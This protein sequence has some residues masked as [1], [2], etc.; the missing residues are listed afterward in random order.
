MISR[1]IRIRA[2][3]VLINKRFLSSSSRSTSRSFTKSTIAS[4]SSAAAAYELDDEPDLFASYS[5]AS[6]VEKAN[7]LY[8]NQIQITETSD[9]GYGVHAIKPFAPGELVLK[10][11]A[12]ATIP[13][14]THTLQK[15]WD[16]HIMVDVPARLLNHS[17][18]AN[19]G[20]M[21]NEEGGYDFIAL[22][23]IEVGEELVWDYES[24]EWEIRGFEKCICG[25]ANCRGSI[26]GFKKHGAEVEAQ[27]GEYIAN[28]LK[29]SSK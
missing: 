7:Q 13:R 15:D 20:L 2:V 24:T 26:G 18:D 23:M 14:D 29:N 10:A 12:L 4:Q 9:R 8:A 1:V 22:R 3:N 21:D 6:D 11:N 5:S 19:V 27:Y 17:C 16:T 25:A 28:Y